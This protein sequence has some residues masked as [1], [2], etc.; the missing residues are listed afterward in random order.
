MLPKSQVVFPAAA[1]VAVSSIRRITGLCESRDLACDSPRLRLIFLTLYASE[2]QQMVRFGQQSFEVV[3]YG[4]GSES[5][6]YC[7][8]RV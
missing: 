6:L 2:W 5:G 7:E 4:L 8:S 3:E 1:F